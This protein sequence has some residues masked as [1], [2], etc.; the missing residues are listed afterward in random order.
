MKK[1][2]FISLAIV[3]FLSLAAMLIPV[4]S[5][6]FNKPVQIQMQ[7]LEIDFPENINA[8]IERS[9]TDCHSD[10]SGNFKAKGKLNFSKWNEYTSVKKVSKLNAICEIVK[11]GKMPKKSYVEKYPEKALSVEEIELI[12]KW[13]D[14]ESKKIVGE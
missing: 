14:D 4:H 12:C 6:D 1:I 3:A 8:L 5:S 9:C 7:G 2:L 11:E 13:V 10:E